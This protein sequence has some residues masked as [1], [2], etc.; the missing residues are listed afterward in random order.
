MD[1]HYMS[2]TS[3]HW[4][5]LVA[6]AMR[7]LPGRW[8]TTCLDRLAPGPDQDLLDGIVGVAGHWVGVAA[9]L[10]RPEGLCRLQ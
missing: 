5:V 10:L 6:M 7:L 4:P 9:A 3:L 8:L 2:K 1:L